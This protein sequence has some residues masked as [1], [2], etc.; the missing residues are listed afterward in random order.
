MCGIALIKLK[1]TVETS[2]GFI[3]YNIYYL[4]TRALLRMLIKYSIITYIQLI[5]NL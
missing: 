3:N 5:G 4:G 2:V 1:L